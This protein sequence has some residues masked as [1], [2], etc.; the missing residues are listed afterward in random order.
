[1]TNSLGLMSG[2]ITAAENEIDALDTLD[3]LSCTATQ[4]VINDDGWRCA[5]PALTRSLAGVFNRTLETAVNV[6]FYTSV[7]IG[8]DGNPV[9]SHYDASNGDLELAIPILAVTGIVFE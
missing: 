1:M 2:Q 6:G 5:D 8:A 4:V 3:E 9:I 7:A